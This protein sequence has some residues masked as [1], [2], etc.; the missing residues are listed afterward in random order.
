M[1]W[2]EFFWIYDAPKPRRSTMTVLPGTTASLRGVSG[3]AGRL[4]STEYAADRS[5]WE[6]TLAAS[7]PS[8]TTGISEMW[9]LDRVGKVC[10]SQPGGRDPAAPSASYFWQTWETYHAHDPFATLNASLMERSSLMLGGEVNMWGEGVDDSNF[11][12][13]VFPSTSAA[14]ERLWSSL[15]SDHLP[16]AGNRLAAHRCALVRAGIRA[17]P[18][19]PGPPC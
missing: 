12:S 8:V 17:A 19:G 15:P 18:I 5:E 9:Y 16:G 10:G 3:D 6:L 13:I 7:I 4:I 14:A 11:D 2:D 1:F